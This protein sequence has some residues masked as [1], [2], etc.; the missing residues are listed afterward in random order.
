MLDEQVPYVGSS[1]NQKSYPKQSK[2]LKS[3]KSEIKLNSR[4]MTGSSKLNTRVSAE[5]SRRYNLK[6]TKSK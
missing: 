1:Q 6:P 2:Q 5:A 3:Y 4:P